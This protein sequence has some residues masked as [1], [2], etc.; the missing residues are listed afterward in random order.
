L[1]S[2]NSQSGINSTDKSHI[3]LISNSIGVRC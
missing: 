3:I 2:T 1:Q